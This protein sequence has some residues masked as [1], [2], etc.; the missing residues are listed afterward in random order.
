MHI[1]NRA[2]L[3]VLSCFFTSMTVAQVGNL[4]TINQSG[5]QI[6]PTEITVCLNA[7]DPNYPLS[8]Q[9]YTVTRAIFSLTPAVQGHS[10]LNAGI[11]LPRGSGFTV[12]TVGSG[13]VQGSGDYCLF[14]MSSSAP[15]T[16]N[17]SSTTI[18]VGQPRDGGVVACLVSAGDD[19]D[20]IA[21]AEDNIEIAW[22][23]IAD[24][25]IGGTSGTDGATNTQSMI[26]QA[27]AVSGAAF[28]CSNLS[29][30]GL[31]NWYLPAINQ[32]SCLYNNRVTIGGFTDNGIYWSSTEAD[33]TQ[34]KVRRFSAGFP[35][36]LNSDKDSKNLVRCVRSFTP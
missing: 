16:I 6:T 1:K 17:V 23:N 9:K 33:A 31:T 20:L 34:A 32:L 7:R 25:L 8:C 14:T 2:F 11:K 3:F 29:T 4:V 18:A 22:S 26:N 21:T 15:A 5:A 24:T 36:P 35:T 12:N 30:G 28:T 13:C 27:G 19:F 10:Y